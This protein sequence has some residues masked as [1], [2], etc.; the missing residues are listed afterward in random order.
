MVVEGLACGVAARKTKKEVE[1]GAAV[2]W[3]RRGAVSWERRG[4][5]S[6]E[7]RGAVSWERRGAYTAY[8][9]HHTVYSIHPTYVSSTQSSP[10]K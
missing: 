9:V 2:S 7:R 1:E 5:V 6:W 4:A 3:E 8:I 10:C